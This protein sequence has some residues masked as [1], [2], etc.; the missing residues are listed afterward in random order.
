MIFNMVGGGGGSL[1]NTDA[2]LIVSV[3]TGSTVTAT[4][5]GVTITP[6]IWVQNADNTLDTAIFSV[7]ASTF[8]S[9]PWTVTATLGASSTSNTVIINSAKE[10]ALE[11][12]FERILFY[13]GTTDAELGTF[14]AVASATIGTELK[15]TANQTNGNYWCSDNSFVVPSKLTTLNFEAEVSSVFGNNTGYRPRFGIASSKITS[16]S[17]DPQQ[18]K[19][20]AYYT[21][22]VTSDY[23]HFTVD[24]SSYVGSSYY[25]A[26]VSIATTAT[27]KIWLS[28]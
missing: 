1:K 17:I 5:G 11:L 27:R 18:K 3:P 21:S 7:K 12:T 24:I 6:T 26:M 15:T 22:G 20:V 13:N 25:V 9:N 2:V 4:K 8:D 14:V 16:G 28:E 19:I 23:V 10:Y